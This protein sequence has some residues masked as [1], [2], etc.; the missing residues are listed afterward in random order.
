[1]P[2]WIWSL[3]VI[4]LT[5]LYFATLRQRVGIREERVK[6]V[7]NSCV[8]DLLALLQER[9]ADLAPALPSTLV[10]INREY[11]SLEDDL[12]DGD[13]VAL[14]PPVS[15][16][17]T[18]KDETLIRITKKELNLNKILAEMGSSSREAVCVLTAVADDRPAQQRD[19]KG[20]YGDNESQ[21]PMSRRDM[22][23]IAREIRNQWP[24][25]RG[26]AIVRCIGLMKAGTPN[27]LI[28][29]SSDHGDADIYH[30]A[31]FGIRRLTHAIISKVGGL[32]QKGDEKSS[33][34][35]HPKV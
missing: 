15:G 33:S 29:C 19:K 6:L 22:H 10:S 8:S 31:R 16:G 9:H 34:T 21:N 18:P 24:A 3:I 11:A 27:V 12:H 35:F 2:A 14:F 5:V 23:Q 26:I 13:E 7:E 1:M 4:Q 28:A 30:A 32:D 20:E 25:V 17:A